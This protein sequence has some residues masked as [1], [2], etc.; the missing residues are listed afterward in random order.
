[1][2]IAIP[3]IVAAIKAQTD[4]LDQV[5]F[6]GFTHQPAEELARGAD[7]DRAARAW[8]MS[9]IPTADRPRSKWR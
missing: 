6:A 7:R 2:A 4:R 5:I 9:S 8:R 1:M 3:R